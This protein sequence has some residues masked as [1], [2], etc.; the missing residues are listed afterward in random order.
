MSSRRWR[1]RRQLRIAC[2]V[3]MLVMVL[4]RHLSYDLEDHRLPGRS[5]LRKA[6]LSPSA[7]ALTAS[8]RITQ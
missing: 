3:T 5:M 4:C 2:L 8:L 7:G 6:R 1:Q